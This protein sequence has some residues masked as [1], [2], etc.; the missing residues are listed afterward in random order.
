M[1]KGFSSSQQH[2]QFKKMTIL[3]SQMDNYLQDLDRNIQGATKDNTHCD[4]YN[5]ME[6]CYLF[7][8][9]LHGIIGTLIFTIGITGNILSLI[10]IHKMNKNKKS[11]TMFLLKSL[12]IVHSAILVIFVFQYAITS[13]LDYVRDVKITN[14]VYMYFRLYLGFPLFCVFHTVSAWITCMLTLH[15]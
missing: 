7:Y 9:V 6:V 4:E 8:F 10:I 3:C 2:S 11:A 1:A 15:R 13:V 5:S 12:A 14:S